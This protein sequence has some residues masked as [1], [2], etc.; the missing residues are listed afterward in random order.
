[1]RSFLKWL[2]AVNK[3]VYYI[4][5]SAC[6]VLILGIIFEL[7]ICLIYKINIWS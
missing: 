5:L 1:M 7:V 3:V 6:A 4:L 2:K